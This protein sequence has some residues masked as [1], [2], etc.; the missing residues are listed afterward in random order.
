MIG[1]DT[2]CFAIAITLADGL[3]RDTPHPRPS[4]AE[5]ANRDGPGLAPSATWRRVLL[6]IRLTATPAMA[7]ARTSWVTS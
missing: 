1:G 6:G 2:A 7:A 4:I 3:P 5:G